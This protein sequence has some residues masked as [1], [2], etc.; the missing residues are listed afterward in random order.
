MTLSKVVLISLGT[1][2]LAIGIIGLVLPGL[3][4]TPFLLLTA[5]LYLR[6]SDR[7][8][9]KVIASKL[10]GPY[11][12]GYRTNKGMTR[13]QKIYSI[14]LMWCMIAVS[15]IVFIKGFIIEIIVI[16]TGVVG[17]LVMGFVI[18]TSDRSQTSGD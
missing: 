18:P 2:S 10:I 3:P 13:N 11:I 4:T 9:K 16:I 5:G 7:L 1:I 8:Y 6:S 12:D 15:C 14:L 17:T